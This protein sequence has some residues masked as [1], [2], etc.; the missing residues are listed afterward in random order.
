MQHDSQING[1][2]NAATKSYDYTSCFQFVKP[3]FESVDLAI[4][5]LELTLAGP[6]FQG[7][8]QFSAPD[9]LP[10]A[11]KDAG[12]DILV[13]ANNHSVDQRKK[14]IERTI[15]ILDSMGIIH[16]GTFRDTVERMNDYPLIVNKNGFK[17]AFLNYTYGTNGITVPRPNIV[18]RI[19]TAVIRKDIEKAKLSNP[20]FIIVFTH[21]GL[22]YQS[23]PS[24]E[25]VRLT[26]FCFKK[27]ARIV[28]GSH[29][30]VL[31]PMEWRKEQNKFVVYSLGNFVSGQRDRYKNGGAMVRLDLS[32]VTKDSI[33]SATLDSARFILEWVYRTTDVK[34]K[35]YVLPVPT[36][37]NDTTGFIKDEG[38]RFMMK[39]FIDDSRKLLRANNLNI[40]EIV[41]QHA[42]KPNDP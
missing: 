24:R 32:K 25:Q 18:N 40:T 12:M 5:N 2:Y 35:Y 10:L 1:A 21:W 30:H 29:P 38:S 4:G 20:D 42:A 41:K 31:Q 13:T 26:E 22:E 34:R 9:A 16:T 33:S 14:G 3:Y 8:P 11:L 27:G 17:L 6:P 28:I 15:Q 39:T 19:D 36:F 37:E 23:Q 7:Y